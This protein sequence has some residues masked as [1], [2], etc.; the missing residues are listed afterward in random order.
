MPDED[1]EQLRTV[2]QLIEYVDL[3]VA[4]ANPAARA[5]EHSHGTGNRNYGP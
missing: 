4:M 2:Q 1:V 5:Q 3:A